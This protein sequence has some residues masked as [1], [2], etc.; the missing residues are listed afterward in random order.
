MYVYIYIYIYIYTILLTL[1]NQVSL[2]PVRV[3]QCIPGGGG[4]YVQTSLEHNLCMLEEQREAGGTIREGQP[5]ASAYPMTQATYSTHL[6][7]KLG[8]VICMVQSTTPQLDHSQ[9]FIATMCHV[10]CAMFPPGEQC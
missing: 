3:V 4:Q 6:G 10:Q 8:V 7:H 9:R 1:D 5:T 2:V